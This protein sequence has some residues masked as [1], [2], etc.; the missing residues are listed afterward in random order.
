MTASDR[1][2][3]TLL[4]RFAPEWEK[5]EPLRQYAVA[6]AGGPGDVV[7]DRVGIVLQ[8][9]LE[10]AVKYGDAVSTVEVQLSI[11]SLRKNA[12]V[13][14]VNRAQPSRIA[15]L[16]KEYDSL[17]ALREAANHAFARALQRLQRL[18]Q[19][20][21]MLGLARIAMEAALTLEVSGDQVTMLARIE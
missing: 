1:H 5:I 13:R 7:A 9:L 14:V 20:S 2:S 6:A 17:P 11:S 19:G 4:V 15:L 3:T 18:P 12:E 16:K 10:N 8:E 21:T